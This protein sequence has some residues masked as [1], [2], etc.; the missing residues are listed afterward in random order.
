MLTRLSNLNH[1]AVYNEGGQ[2][3]GD[4]CMG[5]NINDEIPTI[6]ER[7]K[8]IGDIFNTHSK[9][10]FAFDR[11]DRFDRIYTITDNDKQHENMMCVP[12][13]ANHWFGSYK[14][15]DVRDACNKLRT[16]AKFGDLSTMTT[17]E[18]HTVRK[19]FDIPLKDEK[20]ISINDVFIEKLQTMFS[21]AMGVHDIDVVP[22]K[23]NIY[24]SGDFFVAHKDTP[25]PNLIGTIIVHIDGDYDCMTIGD[26]V[27]SE[28]DGNVLMFYT[29]V[30]HE[31]KPVPNYRQ[32]LSFKVFTQQ[33]TINN[34]NICS[35]IEINDVDIVLVKK[36]A[37]RIDMN[38][39]CAF[40]LQYGY[41][42]SNISH[43]DDETTIHNNLKGNDKTLFEAMRQ[44]GYRIKVVPVVLT[45]QTVIDRYDNYR[46][47]DEEDGLY[48]AGKYDDEGT[49]KTECFYNRHDPSK[50][51]YTGCSD[52]IE[53][54]MTIT[55]LSPIMIAL[56]NENDHEDDDQDD[57]DQDEDEDDQDDQEDVIVDE[58]V[59]KLVTEI[60]GDLMEKDLREHIYYMG[61]GV[62]IGQ[63]DRTNIYV[64]N[65]STGSA[66]DDIYLNTMMVCLKD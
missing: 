42:Y 23:I 66:R 15:Q 3:F 40:L 28:K 64:G 26:K 57:Q 4:I 48:H 27:W 31:V 33:R 51:V 54:I 41:S 6:V 12:L 35:Q 24:E 22:Y 14:I 21:D 58:R 50:Y 53:G 30:L 56:L 16:P 52:E 5:E 20:N 1:C 25:E 34:N 10:S 49:S 7:S 11:S 39:D 13:N 17:R 43:N 32:T 47:D 63:T 59:R 36:L 44:L 55:S 62:R 8:C 45:N 46:E 38:V 37:E 61:L 2:Y 65:Q 18:D 19:G 9:P 29:D 60:Y